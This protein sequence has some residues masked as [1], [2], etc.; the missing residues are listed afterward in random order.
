MTTTG[1]TAVGVIKKYKNFQLGPIDINLKP[2]SATGL[3]GANGA[4]KTTLL[5]CLA[6]QMAPNEGEIQWAD[7]KISLRNWKIREHL[8][9]VTEYASLY[10]TVSAHDH[11]LFASRIF[12]NWDSGFAA[13]WLKKFNLPPHQKVKEYSKG[14]KVKLSIL[15]AI[16]IIPKSSFI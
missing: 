14:M 10:E 9:F 5:N 12:Q 11:L 4:G 8:G 16:S 2:G 1:L 3:L 15:I 7:Q 13:E 6:G